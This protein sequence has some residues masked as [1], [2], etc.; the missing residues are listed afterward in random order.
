MNPCPCG[1]QGSKQQDCSCS[2]TQIARY[3]SKISGPLSDRIDLQIFVQSLS[4]KALNQSKDSSPESSASVQKRVQA[5]Y[6]LQQARYGK[7]NAA[8]SAQDLKTFASLKPEDENWLM[9]LIDD[10]KLSMRTYHRLLKVARTIADMESSS[11]IERPHL[12]LAL[13]L[14][15]RT[16]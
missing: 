2:P 10:L 6:D 12:S 4:L 3:Q 15:V 13:S 16:L 1:Y 7:Q 5:C 9:Q 14:R 11:N 8:L